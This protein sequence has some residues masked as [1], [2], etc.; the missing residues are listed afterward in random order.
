MLQWMEDVFFY[1]SII[2]WYCYFY[3]SD[4]PII[5]HHYEKVSSP[6]HEKKLHLLTLFL[7][8]HADSFAFITPGFWNLCLHIGITGFWCSQRL[9]ITLKKDIK[10]PIMTLMWDWSGTIAVCLPTSLP[11]G[12]KRRRFKDHIPARRGS[13]PSALLLIQGDDVAL[14]FSLGVSCCFLCSYTHVSWSVFILPVFVS[15]P[16]DFNSPN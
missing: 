15:F 12:L 9:K 5:L 4:L 2:L 13:V 7:H 6:N 3:R 16:T 10:I 1:R 8:S 14:A 11:W